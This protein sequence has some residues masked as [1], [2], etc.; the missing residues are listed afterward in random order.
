MKR[1]TGV[2]GWSARKITKVC[3]RLSVFNISMHRDL[4]PS[5]ELTKSENKWSTGH[6]FG[7][8]RLTQMSICAV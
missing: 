1:S 3:C 5:S 2:C 7:E 6:L 4:W 8:A